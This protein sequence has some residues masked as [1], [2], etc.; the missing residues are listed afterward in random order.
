MHILKMY[1]LLSSNKCVWSFNYP[2]SQDIEHFHSL[3]KYPHAP[4]QA[5][6]SPHLKSGVVTD[7]FLVPIV[8]PFIEC[9]LSGSKNNT[10]NK[11]LQIKSE[12]ISKI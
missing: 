9:S 11:Y 5:V 4:L 10:S 2:H 7:L 3:K 6:P 1:C 8:L 12:D